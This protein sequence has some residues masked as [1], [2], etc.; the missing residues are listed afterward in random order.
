[1]VLCL[2]SNVVCSNA[3]LLEPMEVGRKSKRLT[4]DQR[5]NIS[6]LPFP[7][8][9][10]PEKFF[11]YMELLYLIQLFFY[12]NVTFVAPFNRFRSVGRLCSTPCQKQTPHQNEG[13][14][15]P[16]KDNYEQTS[17]LPPKSLVHGSPGSVFV[18]YQIICTVNNCVL[19]F[20]STYIS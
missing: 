10:Q 6:F 17:V 20:T 2:I 11:R 5:Y 15:W 9:L 16:I 19:H 14:H 8:R 4:Q 13:L 18:S 1:M 7:S 3:K 12:P